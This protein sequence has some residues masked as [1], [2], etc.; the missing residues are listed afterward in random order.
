MDEQQEKSL[1]DRVARLEQTVEDLRLTLGLRA[2]AGPGAAPESYPAPTPEVHVPGPLAAGPIQRQA[3]ASAAAPRRR[4]LPDDMYRGEYWLGKVGIGLVLFGV[5]F[6]FKYSID[7]GWLTEPVRLGCGLAIGTALFIAGVRIHAGRRHFSQVLLG[8]AFATFY[9]TGFAAFQL[10]H[11]VPWP[12]AF[13]FMAAATLL[14]FCLSLG[15][16]EMVLALIG[17]VGGLGTPFLL[18]TPEGSLPGLAGY[19]CLVLG[20]AA[21]VYLYRGWRPLLVVSAV[22]AVVVFSIVVSQ[23]VKD[24][25]PFDRWASQLG[26]VFAWLSVWAVPVLRDLLQ[27]QDPGRW[28]GSPAARPGSNLATHLLTLL[29]PLPFLVFSRVIWRLSE[30]SFGWVVLAGGLVYGLVAWGLR[31]R[32]LERLGYTHAVAA[33]AMLTVAFCLLLEGKALLLTLTVEAVALHLVSSRL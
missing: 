12:A 22:G 30:A 7:R 13:A 24:T 15:M 25:P 28:P 10:Y 6:L 16:R 1:L 33:L 8:G 26:V 32:R 3:E 17:T 14:S 18:Y 2:A 5:A 11:L 23:V 31:S 21:A 19:T 20:G 27:A 29:M 9:L 4:A